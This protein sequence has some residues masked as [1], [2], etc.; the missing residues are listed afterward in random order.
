M[1]IQGFSGTLGRCRH[2]LRSQEEYDHER[3]RLRPQLE[4]T[5]G[6]HRPSAATQAADTLRAASRR[7]SDAIDSGREPGMPLDNI[8]QLVREAPLHSLA[9]A[10][11]LGM[12]VARRR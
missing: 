10:F 11:L 12:V 6:N 3:K 7:V 2:W 1:T 8:A 5:V 9:I 4:S